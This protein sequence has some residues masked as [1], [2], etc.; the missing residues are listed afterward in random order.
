MTTNDLSPPQKELLQSLLEDLGLVCT[1]TVGLGSVF[2]SD[3]C[4]LIHLFKQHAI[5]NVNDIGPL[6]PAMSDDVNHFMPPLYRRIYWRLMLGKYGALSIAYVKSTLDKM[7]C[8]HGQLNPFGPKMS[9]FNRC[10]LADHLWVKWNR[11]LKED[12]V[13]IN[14]FLVVICVVMCAS[15]VTYLSAKAVSWLY[16]IG[17]RSAT[18]PTPE[19]FPWKGERYIGLITLFWMFVFGMKWSTKDD[20]V[21]AILSCFRYGLKGYRVLKRFNAVRSKNQ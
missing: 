20:Y 15:V 16:I 19:P 14:W 1:C 5:G 17:E 18:N 2:C 9:R 11:S 8:L 4:K 3:T 21:A 12:R 10:E 6:V 7:R 13:W